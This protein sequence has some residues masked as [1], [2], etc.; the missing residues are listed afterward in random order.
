MTAAWETIVQIAKQG[1]PLAALD[2]LQPL[3]R[4]VDPSLR[5]DGLEAMI[6]IA[7]MVYARGDGE[8]VTQCYRKIFR[9]FA[10]SVGDPDE[11]VRALALEGI[12][13]VLKRGDHE[14]DTGRLIQYA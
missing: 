2:R 6:R 12:S 10:S 3:I 11:N 9:P 8:E 5:Y 13:S 4:D 1:E 14:T 7:L